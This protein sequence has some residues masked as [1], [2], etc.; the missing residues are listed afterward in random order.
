MFSI[1][2]R[3]I[4]REQPEVLALVLEYI[5]EREFYRDQRRPG[6]RM[7]GKEL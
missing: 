3:H 6:S 2:V 4:H 5:I 1:I 7:V